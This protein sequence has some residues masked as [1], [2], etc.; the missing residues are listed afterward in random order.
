[1]SLANC[2]YT[3]CSGTIE[4][5]HVIKVTAIP[6]APA[7]L[8]L[9]ATCQECARN[10]QYV[11]ERSIWDDAQETAEAT[12]HGTG[13]GAVMAAALIE[14]NPVDTVDELISLWAS[15]KHPPLIEEIK[16]ACGCDSCRRRL[17]G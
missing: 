10:G 15:L 8:A 12:P 16:D 14:L 17:Y 4:V 6:R 1:M 7:H 2:K 11:L 9:I 13:E 5:G 3:D